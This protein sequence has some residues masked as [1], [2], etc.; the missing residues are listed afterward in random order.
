MK[1]NLDHLLL[2]FL[3]SKTR[4][5]LFLV[6]DEL[7]RIDYKDGQLLVQSQDEDISCSLGQFSKV[8]NFIYS[9]NYKLP[10]YQLIRN[11]NSKNEFIQLLNSLYD[12]NQIFEKLIEY[13]EA[14]SSS[15]EGR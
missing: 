12:Q 6:D 15:R 2:R 13:L 1:K 7:I 11:Q 10:V 4:S 8:S 3:R 14:P 5:S 9:I